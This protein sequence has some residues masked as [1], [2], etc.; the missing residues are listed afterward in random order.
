M[1]DSSAGQVPEKRTG[2]EHG[3]ETHTASG[4]KTHGAA[5]THMN[6]LQVSLA[7]STFSLYVIVTALSVLD[8]P[9][10]GRPTVY[11]VAAYEIMHS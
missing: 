7:L 8:P 3:Q 10:Q 9:P 4:R 5:A 11:S 6:R 1:C 2:W